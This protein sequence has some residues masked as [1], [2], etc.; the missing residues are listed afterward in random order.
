MAR[1][2]RSFLG[3][4]DVIFEEAELKG[5]SRRKRYNSIDRMENDMSRGT[6]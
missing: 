4:K 6:Q 3:V 5:R 2:Q 1:T